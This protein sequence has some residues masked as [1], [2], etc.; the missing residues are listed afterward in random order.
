MA[1]GD[2]DLI[3]LFLLRY[4]RPN[5]RRS[6]ER[7][8]Q[9]FFGTEVVTL[10]QARQVTFVQVNGYIQALEDADYA[11]ATLRRRIA[12]LRGFFAWLIALGALDTNP[13]DRHVIRRVKRSG[14]SDRAIT[15]LS[16]EQSRQL[17]EAV[18]M[19]H[20]SGV[21]NRALLYTLLHCVLRRSEAAAMNFEH[22]R[23]VGRHWVLDLPSTKGGADQF[24][25][26]PDLVRNQLDDLSSYYGATSGPVWRSLSPNSYG[27]R[28][29][30]TSIYDIVNKTARKAGIQ[31]TV[32]AHTLRH[33]GCTLAIEAGATVQQVQTH[34]RH[35]NLETTMI[36][37][38]QRDKLADSAAD[39]IDL[40]ENGGNE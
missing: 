8:L 3:R 31:A 33:T 21:R 27:R 24:V 25:K 9:S 20:A 15:V 1:S 19:D 38:H 16:K 13:A 29:S 35:K 28:L 40:G 23:P 18:D 22:V 26:L 12:S 17:I 36:Y 32:G 14:G 11:P 4:D 10:N 39:F 34:A 5:T 7:D 2:S 30:T 37:V 6:Y